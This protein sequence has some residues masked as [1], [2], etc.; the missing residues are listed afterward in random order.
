MG[1]PKKLLNV[2]DFDTTPLRIIQLQCFREF[3]SLTAERKALDRDTRRRWPMKTPVR[4]I[5]MV[6]QVDRECP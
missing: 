6:F 2:A 1:A 4:K 5:G 3:P